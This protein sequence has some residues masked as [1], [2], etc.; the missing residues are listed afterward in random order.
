M[1]GGTTK[2]IV[3]AL[4]GSGMADTFNVLVQ[5]PVSQVVAK[6]VT[7]KTTT[8]TLYN[9]SAL[10]SWLPSNASNKNWGLAYT[11]P[12]ASPV[13][14]GIVGIV[15]EWQLAAK[16]PGTARVTVSSRDNPAIKDTFTVTVVRPV[17]GIAVNPQNLAMKVG[18][19]DAAAPLTVNPSDASDKSYTLVSGNQGVATV[20]SGNK[21]HAVGGGTATFTASSNADPTKT[22]SF[23]VTVTVP[24]LSVKADDVP[25]LRIGDAEF[26]PVLT[27]NPATATNKGFSLTSL[28]TSL[29]T[30][31]T[32]AN[33]LHAV[34]PGTGKAIV[35][36]HDG[37]KTDTFSVT[38]VQPVQ[39]ITVGS[40][41]NMKA[42]EDMDPSITWNPSNATN[43]GY[44]LS[45]GNSAI[46]TVVGNRVHAVGSGSAIMTVTTTDGGKSQAFTV[47]V[48]SPV[49]A[50]DA[51]PDITIRTGEPDAVMSPVLSPADAANKAWH[52]VS[53]DPSIASVSGTA[54]HPVSRG[55]VEVIFISNENAA[56]ND[57]IVV[58]V[59]GLFGL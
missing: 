54:I 53:Q 36:S 7:L 2:V 1:A 37:G 5:V 20:A 13:P 47:M 21:V 10:F 28:N 40:P 26:A 46:A 16:G 34:A 45:G 39:S 25:A 19:P 58:S 32:T 4:D 29:F 38:V 22:A 44:I 59:R 56:V 52:M 6:D 43:K 48:T 17:S 8:D 42:G 51:G 33:K 31:N 49:T 35:S 23:T 41:L 15:N 30:I 14:S 18:D 9:P 50:I 24:V 3:R 27:W 11:S 57:T 55:D 12:T